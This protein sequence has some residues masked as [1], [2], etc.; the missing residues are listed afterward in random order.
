[1]PGEFYVE[2]KAEKV[3][4]E[5]VESALAGL[6]T[7][8]DAIKAK[9]DNL[10]GETPGQGSTTADWQVAEV[11][12]VSIG[13][14]DTRYKLH[15]LLLSIHN[16]IGT[17]IM[18]RLYTEVKGSERKVYEQ[19]FNAGTD[20]P[21]VWVVNGTIAIHKP[22]RITLQSN[23]ATDNGKAVDYDYMLEAMQ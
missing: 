14:N 8:A 9:T 5:A 4:L 20:S 2:N 11:N 7:K 17:V 13:S 23:D 3:S 22:L 18:V 6:S 10:A 21:G 19:T 15:S 1:M 12:V 16:L